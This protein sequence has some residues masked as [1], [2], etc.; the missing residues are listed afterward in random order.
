MSVRK[1]VWLDCD[2]GHDDAMAIL[3]AFYASLPEDPA[4]SAIEVLGISTVH[5]NTSSLDTLINAARVLTALNLT[6]RDASLWRG[7]A[8]PLLRH[9][10]VDVGIH[11]ED[12]LG[13]VLGLYVYD[14]VLRLADLASPFQSQQR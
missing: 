1:P 7:A 11:G 6:P 13:G 12:G 8:K 2:P 4:Q 3:L 14:F 9:A 5:G 10:Q